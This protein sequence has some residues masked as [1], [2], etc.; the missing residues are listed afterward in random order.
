LGHE[1]EEEKDYRYGA[2][3]IDEGDSTKVQEW[4]PDWGAEGS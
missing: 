1:S 2:Y 3:A 4:F